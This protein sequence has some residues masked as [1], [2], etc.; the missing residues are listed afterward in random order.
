MLVIGSRGSD[1]ALAQTRWIQKRI[2]SL[3]PDLDVSIR[4]V[5]T[6][7]D[8]DTTS[9]IRTGSSVGVFV[10]ELERA[11]LENEIDM[12]VHSMKDLPTRIQP[13]LKIAAIPEREEV[14]DALVTSDKSGFASLRPN[15]RIGTGSIRRQA[16]MLALRP[17]LQI[18]D[19]RGNINTRLEKLE[20]GKYDAII[21][22][23]AGLNRLNLQNRVS[24]I[25]T[26]EQMLPAPGQ[27]A[28]AVETRMDDPENANVAAALNHEPTSIAV[29][30]ERVFL[31]RMEG[32]CNVPVA[33]HARV[34]DNRISIDGLVISPGG[35][36][37]IRESVCDRQESADRAAALLADRILERGGRGILNDL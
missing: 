32:G 35:D 1:L 25:F 29:T 18:V 17:D 37:S 20:K 36:K 5:K 12:A 6:S 13:G 31:K 21:L 4:I 27:G 8:K 30:A 33:V 14:R 3:F 19:V 10:K 28:L 22:A 11:L 7:G 24:E 26:L 9:S 34:E 2:L 16:Q 15:S 23:V